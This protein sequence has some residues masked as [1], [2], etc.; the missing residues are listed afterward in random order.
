MGTQVQS[1]RGHEAG[2]ASMQVE[3]MIEAAHIIA[4]GQYVAAVKAAEIGATTA[5]H[6]HRTGT[7][8]VLR[9]WASKSA[10]G[11][12]MAATHEESIGWFSP[13]SAL[14]LALAIK[15]V[16]ASDVLHGCHKLQQAIML[17]LRWDSLK[18]LA[19]VQILVRSGEGGLVAAFD[20]STPGCGVYV[21]VNADIEADRT[22]S[23]REWCESEDLRHR[24]ERMPIPD[25]LHHQLHKERQRG[26]ASGVRQHVPGY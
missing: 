25:S 3:G 22:R 11:G 24:L 26:A 23:I 20:C 8:N 10:F 4:Q 19:I 7:L 21:T 18:D 5:M 9:V 1:Q 15:G 14:P 12:G 17:G 13:D 16:A 2:L 6:I